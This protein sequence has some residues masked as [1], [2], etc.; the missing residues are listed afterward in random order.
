MCLDILTVVVPLYPTLHR[1]L[2]VP[3][4]TV[5]LKLLD[6]SAF[7][8]PIRIVNSACRLHACLHATGGKVGASGLW[9]KSL[10]ETIGFCVTALS[11]LR[12]TT[13]A[14]GEQLRSPCQHISKPPLNRTY[15]R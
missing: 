15:S 12:T 8:T 7:S 11:S 5:T 3:L 10:D 6:G 1:Q 2:H 4:S 14:N 13:L 9:R